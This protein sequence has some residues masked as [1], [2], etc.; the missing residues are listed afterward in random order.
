MDVERLMTDE[1]EHWE[2]LRSAFEQVP[3][4]RFEEASLTADG[5]SPKDLLFHV[6]A[7]QH[8][9]TAV[10]ERERTGAPAPEGHTDTDEKNARFLQT[11]QGMSAGEVREAVEPVRKRMIAGFTALDE[12]TTKAWEWFEESGPIHYAEHEGELRGWLDAHLDY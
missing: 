4:A 7:W 1:R 8:E 3:E 10:L 12:V 2:R 9:C 6:T 11:S 5:W